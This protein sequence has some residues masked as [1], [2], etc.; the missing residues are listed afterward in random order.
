M[1][2]SKAPAG[3][4]SAPAHADARAVASARE[5]AEQRSRLTALVKQLPYE[6][7]IE[8][9][10]HAAAD[11]SNAQKLLRLSKELHEHLSTHVYATVT[12]ASAKSIE[13]FYDLVRTKPD[14]GRRVKS[15]WIGECYPTTHRVIAG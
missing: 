9:L 15:L 3:H 5:Q 10:R 1:R 13:N 8:C 7:F 4:G 11:Q 14:I 6:L 12:L 2:R